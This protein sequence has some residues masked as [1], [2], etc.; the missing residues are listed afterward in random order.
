LKEIKKALLKYG[1]HD[2]I[3]FKD[4]ALVVDDKKIVLNSDSLF[5]VD[6]GYRILHTY[7]FAISSPKH[8]VR[9]V[10]V[11]DLESYHEIVTST[12]AIKFDIE[13]ESMPK[14]VTIRRQYGMRKILKDEFDPDRHILKIGFDDF[15]PCPYGHTFK[16]LGYDI[17]ERVYVRLSSTIIKDPKLKKIYKEKI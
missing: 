15:P 1:Y 12:F 14:T 2:S 13:V 16:M 6:A 3:S 7:L 11:L 9:G 4:N 17:K 10:L 5:F 8:E